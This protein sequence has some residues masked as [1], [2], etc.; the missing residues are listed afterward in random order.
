MSYTQLSASERNQVYELRTTT[1]LAMRAIAPVNWD[2]I[3]ARYRE[4]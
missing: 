3:R 4:S 2:E 1:G